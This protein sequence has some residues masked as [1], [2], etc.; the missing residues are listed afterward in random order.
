MSVTRITAARSRSSALLPILL[1]P[2]I[3]T[4]VGCT[5]DPLADA[6]EV[7]DAISR[8]ETNYPDARTRKVVLLGFDSCDPDLVDRLIRE[9]KLPNFARIRREGAHGDLLSLTPL[10]SPVI[11]TTIATGMS[12]ERHGILDFV[13][14]TPKGS[15]PVSSRMRQADTVWELVARAGEPVGVVGWLVSWPADEINGYLVSDRLG[16]LAFEGERGAGPAEAQAAW[17]PGLAAEL[18]PDRVTI[19]DVPLSRLRAFVDV[20]EEEY[21]DAYTNSFSDDTNLLGGLRLIMAD[22]FTFRNVSTRLKRE[23]DPRLFVAYFNAMDALSHYFMPFAPPKMP[24]IPADEYMKFKDVIEANY[25]WHDAVLGEYLRMAEEDGNT[26][27]MVVSDHGFKHGSLRMPESSQF[28]AKTGAMWHRRY[29]VIY[30]WGGGVAAGERIAGASVYDVAPTILAA[31][32]YPVPDDMPGRVLEDLYDEGLPHETVPTWFGESRRLEIAAD[33]ATVAG[34]EAAEVSPEDREELA[35]LESLGYRGGERS[36]SASGTLNLAARF[37]AKGQV[38]RA[39]QEYEALLAMPMW[40]ENGDG[41]RRLRYD[42]VRVRLAAADAHVRF[43]EGLRPRKG[44]AAADEQLD[45]ADA[46]VHEVVTMG[47]D[48]M[49]LLLVGCKIARERGDLPRAEAMA[50]RAV[51]LKPWNASGH[52]V[53]ASVLRIRM[54][55][56]TEAGDE[57]EARR[58]RRDAI[59]ALRAALEREPRQWHALNELAHMLLGDEEADIR[60]QAE[61][62]LKQLERALELIP[63]SPKALNNSAIALLRIAITAEDQAERTERLDEA[64]AAADAA[65]AVKEAYPLGW[66]NRA[67]VL[68]QMDL[69]D[70]AREAALRGREFDPAYRFNAFFLDAL[71]KFGEALPPPEAPKPDPPSPDDD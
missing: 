29:G 57:A 20:T 26:T 55:A 64:L 9:G 13:T 33:S 43:A 38:K 2:A 50:R 59:D 67:Y 1:A 27:V 69:L 39:L 40:I 15:R 17:P 5:A 35:K 44:D 42:P 28:K 45:K 52:N 14:E 49:A 56:A 21:A 58:F 68:W 60:K 63:K 7:R 47:G 66:A 31:M 11:W 24:Q 12:P 36:D 34:V 62:A 3:L 51:E 54:E 23:K 6:P 22:A 10:L 70:E 8:A 37:L 71:A 48:E 4:L 16:R 53:L 25:R 46:Y 61:E 18:A 19:D 30:A 41:T 32:G 65:L